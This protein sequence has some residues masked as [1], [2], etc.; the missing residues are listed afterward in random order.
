MSMITPLKIARLSGIRAARE[1]L[2]IDDVFGYVVQRRGKTHV[3]RL[4]LLI[5]LLELLICLH[6]LN[7][8][9][10]CS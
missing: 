8:G 6:Q 9:G 1:H 4:Q 7:E 10:Q 3:L 2:G 5:L